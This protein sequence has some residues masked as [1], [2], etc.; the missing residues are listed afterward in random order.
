MQDEID[1]NIKNCVKTIEVND[2]YRNNKSL[3]AHCYER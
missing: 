3:R 1:I 2:N